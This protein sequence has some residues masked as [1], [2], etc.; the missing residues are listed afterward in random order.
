[1]WGDGLWGG[2]AGFE[3]RP[4]WNYDLMAAGY[5]FALLPTLGI[6]LGGGVVLARIFR[7]PSADSFLLAGLPIAFGAALIYMTLRVP[8]YSQVKAFYGML[9]L[10]PVCV[11]AVVGLDVLCQRGRLLRLLVCGA[12]VVWAANSY[13]SFWIRG[14]SVPVL[15]AAGRQLVGAGHPLEAAEQFAA[16]LQ[17]DPHH[18]QPR[19]YLAWLLVQNGQAAEAATLAGQAIAEQPGNADSHVALGIALAAQGRKQEAIESLRHAINLAPEHLM[20]HQKLA[21]LLAEMR[22]IEECLNTCRE[23]LRVAPVDPELHRLLKKTQ[24]LP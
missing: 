21:A 8:C 2:A 3:F 17:E 10:L 19:K 16:A 11:F 14:S 22:M 1:L 15:L 13:A 5:L 20:A 23:G 24:T 12:L 7:Q 18:P 4:P 9:A 6:L